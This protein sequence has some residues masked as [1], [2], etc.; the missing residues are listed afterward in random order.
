LSVAEYREGL[1][2]L[3]EFVSKHSH[4]GQCLVLYFVKAPLS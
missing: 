1:Y 3:V 2:R 4:M